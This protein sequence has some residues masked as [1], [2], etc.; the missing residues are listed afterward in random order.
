MS[1]GLS[2][3]RVGWDVGVAI[4]GPIEGSCG[5]E[6]VLYLDCITVNIPVVILY[7]FQCHCKTV[8][9]LLESQ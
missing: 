8:M 5:D 9:S 6:S 4:K 1:Q 3:E 2:R 7:Y